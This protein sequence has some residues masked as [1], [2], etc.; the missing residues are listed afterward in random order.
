MNREHEPDCLAI[1]PRD[2][3]RHHGC[4]VRHAGP[5][6]VAVSVSRVQELTAVEIEQQGIQI[7]ERSNH[8]GIAR[9]FRHALHTRGGNDRPVAINQVVGDLNRPQQ[10]DGP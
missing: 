3:H 9:V 6:V 10:I 7:E 1:F 2:V 5:V 8:G 4:V